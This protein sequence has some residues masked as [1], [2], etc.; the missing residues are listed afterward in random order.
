MRGCTVSRWYKDV[1]NCDVFSVVNVYLDH[2][3][4]QFELIEFV[5]DPFMLTCS[6]M[7]FISLLLLGL[8]DVCS[9]VVFGL[10][11]RLSW[12]RIWTR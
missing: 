9:H 1:C 11:V 12:Y 3:N 2:W 6:M 8:C 5:L 4:K 7:R 10:S